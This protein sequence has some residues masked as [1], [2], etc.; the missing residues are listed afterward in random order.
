MDEIARIAAANAAAAGA[1]SAE[2][3]Q[4]SGSIEGIAAVSEENA[5]A[6]EHVAGATAHLTQQ[7]RT[8]LAA[9]HELSSI[10]DR[11]DDLVGQFSLGDVPA[12][13]VVRGGPV[14]VRRRAA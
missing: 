11:L 2:A 5:S 13:A 14:A 9:S 8:V 7:G 4:V 1:M 3:G 10:V 6:I 12:P